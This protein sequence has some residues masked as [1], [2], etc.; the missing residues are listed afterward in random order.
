MPTFDTF[1]PRS[2]A[3]YTLGAGATQSVAIPLGTNQVQVLCTLAPGRVG[4]GTDAAAPAL[5]DSS[6]GYL[7]A[8]IPVTIKVVG[9]RESRL[10]LGSG[11]ASNIFYITFGN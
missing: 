6:Y 3:T 11:V 8:N 4:V 1:R 2:G 9:G 7:G 5:A 10:Y